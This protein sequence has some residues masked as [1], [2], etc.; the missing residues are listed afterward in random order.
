MKKILLFAL[1]LCLIPAV[2]AINIKV[3]K[4]STRPVMIKELP[5][6]ATYE[7][8]ITNYGKTDEFRF[9]NLLG[10]EMYPSKSIK[11]KA[12]ETKE[13]SLIIYPRE[14]VEVKNTYPLEF[15][16]RASD[17]S[18]VIETAYIRFVSLRDAFSLDAEP[19][20]P[21][22][23]QIHIQFQ[24][25]ENIEFENLTLELSSSFFNFKKEFSLSSFE[26]KNLTIDLDREKS[27]FLSA[28][29]YTIQGF[30]EVQGKKA[31]I[32]GIIEFSAKEGLTTDEIKS[33]FFVISTIIEKTNKGNVPKTSQVRI[34]KNII[35]RLFTS[36]SQEPDSVTRN[37]WKTTYVWNLKLNPGE[38]KKITA[39]TN[40]FLPFFILIL[41]VAII[42]LAKKYKETDLI[43]KKKVSYV[44]TKGGEFALRISIYLK[45]RKYLENI[46]VTDRFPAMVQV[47]EKFGTQIPSKINEKTRTIRWNFQKLENGETRVLSYII[48]SK[49]GVLGKFALPSAI[50]IYERDGEIQESQS[51]RAFFISETR[52]EKAE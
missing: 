48:Y 17:D 46:G 37:G 33:G 24:N 3:E 14:D 28:G 9:Y 30:V 8:I 6:P 36:F 19:I 52:D 22:S 47:Y 10:F 20:Y 27:K 49:V 39:K 2:L 18:E 43:M 15:R 42:V 51:N 21:I 12:N 44:R 1:I 11:V 26:K 5:T 45:A 25:K 23:D 13:I 50:A 34:E 29:F 32:Q 31:D 41:I 7:L 40:W 38:T 16:I 4:V 35:S